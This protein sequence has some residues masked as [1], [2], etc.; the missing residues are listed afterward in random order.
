MRALMASSGDWEEARH[1]GAVAL[2]AVDLDGAAVLLHHLVADGQP[3]AEPALLGGEERIEDAR[4]RRRRIAAAL[5]EH[6]HLHHAALARAHVDLAEER[7]H[8]HAR[9]EREQAA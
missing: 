2:D 4:A 3:Q 1:R 6:L 9:G 5:V 8:A 7:V